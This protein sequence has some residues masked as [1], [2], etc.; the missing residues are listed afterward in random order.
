MDAAVLKSVVGCRP[1]SVAAGLLVGGQL[2]CYHSG[3][4]RGEMAAQQPFVTGPRQR[5]SHHMN[6]CGEAD[7]GSGSLSSVLLQRTR[8]GST[9]VAWQWRRGR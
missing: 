4:G 8:W 3:Q 9:C 6:P 7:E 2:V 5:L 1:P